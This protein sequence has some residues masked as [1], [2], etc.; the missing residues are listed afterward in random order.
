MRARRRCEVALEEPE[1]PSAPQYRRI[2][3]QGARNAV[4]KLRPA[5]PPPTHT[6]SYTSGDAAVANLRDRRYNDLAHDEHIY[7]LKALGALPTT[8]LTILS[9]RCRS[10]SSLGLS[11]NPNA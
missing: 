3:Y 1:Y 2:E 8:I 6:T 7:G 10:A 11:S 9:S 5:G 4:N